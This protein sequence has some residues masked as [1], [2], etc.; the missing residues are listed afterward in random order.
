MIQSLNTASTGLSTAKTQVENVMNNLANENSDGYKTRNVDAAESKQLDN[1]TAGRG[2]TVISVT[3]QTDI[4]MFENLMNEEGKSSGLSELN[5]MLEEIENIFYETE[6][7]GLSADLNRFFESLENLRL[8]PYNEIYRNDLINNGNIL[9]DNIKSLYNDINEMET[10]FLSKL[11]SEV[12]VVNNIL[13]EIAQTND[14]M[15]S[16]HYATNDL[17]DKRDALE[18]ELSK[19][20]DID[21]ASVGEYNVKIGGQYA[22]SFYDNPHE[23]EVATDYIAQRDVYGEYDTGAGIVPAPYVSNLIDTTSWGTTA[24]VSEVQ[25]LGLTGL[26]TGQ[27]YFLGTAVANADGSAGHQSPVEIANDIAADANIITQ[28]NAANPGREIATITATGGGG[29]EITY[30]NTEGDVVRVPSS[31][32]SGIEFTASYETTKGVLDSVTYTINNDTSVTVFDGE[33]VNGLTVDASN[34][35][36]ALVYKINNTAGI[37]EHVTAYNG[38]YSLDEDGNVVLKTPTT[39]D[40]Y[41]VIESNTEGESGKFVGDIVVED[42]TKTVKRVKV[43]KDTNTSKIGTDEVYLTLH[44]ERVDVSSGSFATIVENLTSTDSNNKIIE[45]KN[46]LDNFVN[47]F[48]DMTSTYIEVSQDNYVYGK[49]ASF[50]HSDY[51]KKQDIGLFT[52]STVDTFEFSSTMVYTLTQPD[53][54]YLATVRWKDDIAF[55]DSGDRTTSFLGYYQSLRVTIAQDR[56]LVIQREETQSAVKDAIEKTYDQLTK[57]DKDKEMVE[58]IK[59]QAAYEANAK[60]IT[61]VDEMLATILGMKK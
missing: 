3:R 9:V 7:S 40:H 46:M 36:Q 41:L 10:S 58:L 59:F 24:A 34:V 33:V 45:Y 6:E 49:D 26:A 17:L 55:D 38:P 43:E 31:I 18:L 30:A 56:E 35:V 16:K 13:K 42:D 48:V 57:V 20:T 12:L 32:S 1:R 2:S 22:V 39:Q 61:V 60:I 15:M 52:G 8:S 54:D 47:K 4:Y 37:K 28:W 5:T 25:S 53:L 50:V 19:F 27:V 23:M 14:E 11:D 29:L 21:V 51:D 44:E